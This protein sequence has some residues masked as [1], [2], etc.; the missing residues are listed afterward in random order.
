VRARLASAVVALS[1]ALALVSPARADLG[2]DVERLRTSWALEG[3]TERLAPRLAERSGPSIV[4]VPPELL[5]PGAPPCASVTVIAPSST[6]FTVRA[7]GGSAIPESIDDFPQ[8]SLAG[9]VQ[10]TRCGRGR[11]RLGALLVEMRSPRAVIETLVVTSKEPARSAV[12]ILP[13]RDP[14]PIA[15][16][17]SSGPRPPPSPIDDRLAA[18]DARARRAQARSLDRESIPSSLRGTGTIRQSVEAGCHRL[19]L[20]AEAPKDGDTSYDLVVA[21]SLDAG[22]SLVTVERGDGLDAAVTLCAGERSAVEIEFAG[23]PSAARVW[24]VR[25]SFAL[26]AVLPESWGSLG[27][28]RIAAVL[29]RHGVRVTGSPVDQT[30]GI[31]GPTWMPI[32]VE[33]GACYVGV[34][35]A[36]RGEPFALALAAA[37]RD[38]VAQNHGG[39]RGDGTLITFC[40]RAEPRVLVEVDS[41]GPGLIW[42][43]ALFQS[44]RV[45]LGEEPSQ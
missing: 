8:A 23:A 24:T 13:Q 10:I 36:V 5:A 34:L 16:L 11:A 33:P 31:Q 43:F 21:P 42:L 28:A 32:P 17:T 18:A 7:V 45:A 6:H 25:S 29:R 38:I 9:L 14:G 19:E 44:G 30:L 27:R 15:P 40:A 39:P 2:E 1:S 12:E 26:P 41:R 4:F 35:A 20:M 22:A 37:G 3:R